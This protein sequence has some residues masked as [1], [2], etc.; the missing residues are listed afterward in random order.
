M[1]I[2]RFADKLSAVILLRAIRAAMMQS[3]QIISA[4]VG[5]RNMVGASVNPFGRGEDGRL[6]Y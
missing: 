4:R 1:L 5:G 6:G 2:L 3:E